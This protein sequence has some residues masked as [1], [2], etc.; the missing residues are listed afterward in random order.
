VQRVADRVRVFLSS[1]W[2]DLQAERHAVERALHR[3]QDADFVGMEYFGSRPETPRAASLAEVDRSDIYV[4]LFGRRYGSGITEAEYRRARER[5]LPC[6]IYVIDE[7]VTS[8]TPDG[9]E[10][11]ED[12]TGLVALK[13]ELASDQ[14]IS[15]F[16]SPDD[17]ATK[18]TADLHSLL[19]RRRPRYTIALSPQEQDNRRR[20][21]ARVGNE[22]GETPM[23]RIGEPDDIAGAV[24]YLAS[25]LAGYVTGVA[26]DVNG[27]LFMG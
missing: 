25:D 20:M 15:P 3:M 23:G 24:L 9:V 12:A 7:Q 17:L 6:L 26:L 27:G 14:T 5:S 10:S 1:T 22:V 18:V 2:E 8:S 11:P 21:L 19:I 16:R 13:R 4:G